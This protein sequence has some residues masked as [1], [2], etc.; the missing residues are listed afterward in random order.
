MN[1]M[2][3]MQGAIASRPASCD[4]CVQMC[5]AMIS[6]RRSRL[7]AGDRR[8]GCRARARTGGLDGRV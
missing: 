6:G 2:L 5:F 3:Q 7:R 1:A 4:P 8:R